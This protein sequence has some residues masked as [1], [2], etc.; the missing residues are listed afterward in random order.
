MMEMEKTETLEKPRGSAGGGREEDVEEDI[1]GSF[2]ITRM[3]RISNEN[4]KVC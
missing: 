1:E 4:L 2:G 3:E